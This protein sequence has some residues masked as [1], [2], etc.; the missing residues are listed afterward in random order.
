MNIPKIKQYINEYKKEF[1]RIHN[2]EIYKWVAVK[3]FQDS[4]D[5]NNTDFHKMLTKSLSKTTNLMDSGN[6]FPRKMILRNAQKTP[7][8]IRTLFKD[9]YNQD[10]DLIE[11]VVNFSS[12]MK[13]I[14][15]ENFR[16]EK[17]KAY[18]DDRAIIVYLN[19]MYPE[20][21]YFYK[22]GMFEKLVEAIDYHYIP[23]SGKR[24]NITQFYSVCDLIKDELKKENELIRLHHS[25]LNEDHY[26]DPEYHILTQDFIYAIT[27]HLKPEEILP[28]HSGELNLVS[29]PI[30]IKDKKITL[31]GSHVDYV[32]KARVNK[33]T[34][35]L[36]ELLI[37]QYE[38][39]CV[40]EKY[41]HLISQVSKDLGD[42]LGYDIL[43]FDESGKEKFIE[44]KTTKSGLN[45]PFLITAS[46]LQKSL[47]DPGNYYLYR[48]YHFNIDLNSGDL[49]ILQGDLSKYCNN[50]VQFEVQI[51]KQ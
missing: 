18:Q 23:K 38:K 36:G 42:G 39:K 43:S 8:D 35:D 48:I 27:E 10:T 11:R 24:S 9:L 40:N 15:A 47:E 7:E 46:E 50:P 14:N 37:L 29:F 12:S 20:E 22:F 3:Q 26:Q 41:Q 33:H 19:L 34:G 5:I 30:K 1:H 51:S 25:R 31:K 17:L 49:M 45:T 44:V 6:Y 4:F 16:V 21:N 28:L 13:Q 2:M 32:K